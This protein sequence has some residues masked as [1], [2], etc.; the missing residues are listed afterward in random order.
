MTADAKEGRVATEEHA[1]LNAAWEQIN[2]I[3]GTHEQHDDVGRGINHA[4]GLALNVIEGLGGSDP[5]TRPIA[6]SIN[7]LPDRLRRYI[8]DIET[9]CDPSGDTRE[10]FRLREENANLRTE[11]ARLSPHQKLIADMLAALRP[12][13]I[14]IDKG[15]HD[16]TPLLFLSNGMCKAKDFRRAL[17]AIAQARP[18]K[19][20]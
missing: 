18:T 16:E 11:C 6:E 15:C 5:L 8:H 17:A 12:F 4:V 2:A 7:A 13:A 10:L 9:K 14:E 20:A 19:G 3:G 1:M